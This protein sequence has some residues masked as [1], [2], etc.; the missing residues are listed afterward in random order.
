MKH[1]K[2]VQAAYQEFL[3]K[4]PEDH[5]KVPEAYYCIATSKLNRR[6][7]SDERL[8]A[9]ILA[10]YEKGLAAEKKLLSCYLPYNS[11]SKTMLQSLMPIL[12]GEKFHM[13]KPSKTSVEA[14][15]IKAS[16]PAPKLYLKDP[17]RIMIIKEHRDTLNSMRKIMKD[18]DDGK[19]NFQVNM[20]KPPKLSQKIPKSLANLQNIQLREM[21]PALDKIYE[22][23][24]INLMIIEKPV[25]GYSS[26]HC[27]AQDDRGDATRLFVYNIPQDKETAENRL[28]L[29]CRLSV[30]N[31]YLR[32]AADLKN[33]LRV[34]DPKCLIQME[35]VENTCWYCGEGGANSNCSRCKKANYC[36][37]EC[38]KADWKIL[39]HKAICEDVK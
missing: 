36:N 33:G 14:P 6:L 26:V 28:G 37:R 7:N 15:T 25:F 34:D 30:I 35:K 13:K 18:A 12:S 1:D 8:K 32:I 10:N 3:D 24:I 29:G 22:G 9:E 39:N 31:P 2:D 17:K 4:A 21:D 11:S 20:T 19:G 23:H 5:R 16:T 27:I 38:Q